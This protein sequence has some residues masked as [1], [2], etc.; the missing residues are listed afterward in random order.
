[1]SP[2]F[3]IFSRSHIAAVVIVALLITMLILRLRRHPPHI[4]DKRL[5]RWLVVLIVVNEVF[6]KIMSIR[7]GYFTWDDDLP[8]HLCG[9]SPFLLAIYLW[10]PNQTLFDVLYYWTLA[11]AILALLLPEMQNGYPS[12]EFSGFFITHGLPL[13]ALLYL[14]LIQGVK[15]SPKSYLTAF[16]AVNLYAL[17]IAAPVNLLVDGNYVY[18]CRYPKV[19]FALMDLMPPWPWYIPLIDLFALAIF[20]LMY[21]PFHLRASAGEDASML[22]EKSAS[23]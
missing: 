17:F 13:Y 22:A 10:K 23:R 7:D 11:G 18:L 16:I 6:W 21:Q 20:R 8:F 14:I 2:P 1:M 15:P 4:D 12:S 5:N 3:V 9:I 19:D